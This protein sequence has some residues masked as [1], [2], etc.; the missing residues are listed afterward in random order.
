[1]LIEKYK[2][3]NLKCRR[4]DVSCSVHAKNLTSYITRLTL[5]YHYQTKIQRTVSSFRIASF[6][7]IN[8]MSI[9][10]PKQEGKLLFI[11][12]PEEHTILHETF[13]TDQSQYGVSKE[14]EDISDD[15]ENDI[16]GDDKENTNIYKARIFYMTHRESP[17]EVDPA[18]K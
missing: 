13:E 14:D 4:Q 5:L 1:M 11:F 17:F 15:D 6:F 8:C 7:N 2:T 3:Y 16:N 12:R 18:Y 9:I 10:N